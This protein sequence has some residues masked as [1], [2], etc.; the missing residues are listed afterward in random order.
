[1]SEDNK[2]LIDQVAQA[3]L[4]K[5]KGLSEK[6]AKKVLNE[7]T[8]SV[9]SIVKKYS[10]LIAEQEKEAAKSKEKAAK[11]AANDEGFRDIVAE[12]EKKHLDTLK[13]LIPV[14]EQSSLLSHVKRIINHLETLLDGCFLLG[15]L[16]PR[17][18]DTILSF[19]ELLSSYIIAEALK[20][21]L[22]NIPQTTPLGLILLIS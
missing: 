13:E 12:I 4:P 19:G 14:S 7:T 8:K 1:M 3:I 11:A 16:S 5:L 18:A 2:K 10:K 21:H 17:T 22:K 20:Q 15:E 6:N 9:S